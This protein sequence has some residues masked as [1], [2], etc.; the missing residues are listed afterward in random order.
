M[1]QAPGK[2]R[3]PLDAM[4]DEGRAFH[5]KNKIA[6]A[7]A[8]Y[9]RVLKV[10]ARHPTANHY[11]GVLLLQQGQTAEALT[12]LRLAV[13]LT[14]N[15]SSIR[16]NLGVAL[17]RMGALEEAELEF[18]AALALNPKAQDALSNLM[19][20][21]VSAERW[22][23]ALQPAERLL[24]LQ[25]GRSDLLMEISRIHLS[26]GQVTEAIEPLRQILV[27]NPGHI[28]ALSNL[29]VALRRADRQEEAVAVLESARSLA[30][31]STEVLVN[32]G[33]ALQTL[34]R[35]GEAISI[36]SHCIKL[37]NQDGFAWHNLG[38]A[39]RAENRLADA[40]TAS[41]SAV[42]R[43]PGSPEIRMGHSVNLLLC[44]QLTEGFQYYESR[45][46]VADFPSPKRNFQ[47]PAW[48]DQDLK[49]K[50]ILIHD[51]QGVGDA[52]QF[53]RYATLL[54]NAGASVVVDCNVQL[55]R[56]FRSARDVDVVVPRFTEIPPVDF[57]VPMVSLAHRFGT[58][59]E[60]IPADIP[61]LNAEPDL[62]AHWAK[63]LG[64]R[65]RQLRVGL[66]W[67]GNPEFR[68]DRLRSP[69]LD[70]ILPLLNVPG[71]K[72]FALQKGPGRR[73]LE[74]LGQPLNLTDLG[75]EISDFADTAAIMM[76]LDLVLTSCTGPAH[77]AGALGVPTWI[78]LP[79]ECDW[80]WMLNRSDS[81]WYPTVR[82][83]RQPGRDLWPQL[84]ETIAAPLAEF[85][86]HSR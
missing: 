36:L 29:G 51:E 1:R 68:G 66:V 7:Q 58:V 46:Q 30:P 61:Y 77:L 74:R 65:N 21:L 64:D 73:D 55:S 83:F 49:G 72:F 37:P 84:V 6:E 25:P 11:M 57:F 56:L 50:R 63:K 18:R 53:V 70:P 69:G 42:A 23:E 19:S 81:P 82:L 60:T 17:K 38:N 67:S 59:L 22:K 15:D 5:A 75:P 4:V 35:F 12:H 31:D 85:A 44:G 26:I 27:T 79:Y 40:L 16:S 32:L 43:S 2:R 52:I 9:T 45:S 20:L 13:T 33:S 54:K 78:M 48:T 8:I 34:D 41:R 76:N 80:R 62:T 28:G 3:S 86:S 24:S 71:V 39:Y 10:A 14:P 47:I